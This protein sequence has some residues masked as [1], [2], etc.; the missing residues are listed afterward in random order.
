MLPPRY[1]LKKNRMLT[2]WNYLG[3]LAFKV[4]I[5][6]LQLTTDLDLFIIERMLRNTCGFR[7]VDGLHNQHHVM[8]A[9]PG[10]SSSH[11]VLYNWLP[12]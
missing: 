2:R 8:P 3:Q 7:G 1:N 10:P 11:L 6:F 12:L 5:P 4:I 9:P